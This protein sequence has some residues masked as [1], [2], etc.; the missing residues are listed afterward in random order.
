MMLEFIITAALNT[1]KLVNPVRT[2][3]W[4]VLN[5]YYNLILLLSQFMAF[6]QE[7]NS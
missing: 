3:V 5:C 4:I 2:W 7:I 6:V 1:C